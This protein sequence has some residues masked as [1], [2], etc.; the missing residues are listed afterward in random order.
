MHTLHFF[1]ELSASDN[2]IIEL[3]ESIGSRELRPGDGCQWMKVKIVNGCAG[4]V[5]ES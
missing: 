4:E 3:V 2:I 5:Q 1:E